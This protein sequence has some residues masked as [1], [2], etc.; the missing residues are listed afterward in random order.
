MASRLIGTRLFFSSHCTTLAQRWAQDLTRGLNSFRCS[1]YM[2]VAGWGRPAGVSLS[3]HPH[4]VCP[5]SLNPH[6][7]IR[8]LHRPVPVQRR[9]RFTKWAVSHSNLEV[10]IG[11]ERELVWCCL[12]MAG[13]MSQSASVGAVIK[14]FKRINEAVS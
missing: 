11:T 4:V 5:S 6:F 9:F 12:E 2:V 13:P 3:V 10:A 1:W 8:G 14:G 7:Y